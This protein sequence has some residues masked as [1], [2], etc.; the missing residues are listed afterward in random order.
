VFGHGNHVEVQEPFQNMYS[1]LTSRTSFPHPEFCSEMSV[2]CVT[3]E[4]YV[5]KS[6]ECGKSGQM[7][8]EAWAC[9]F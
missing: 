5:L 6:S 3:M 8:I 2:M 4:W 1:M 9:S 7:F